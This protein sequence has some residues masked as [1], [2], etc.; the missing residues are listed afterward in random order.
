MKKR[1]FLIIALFFFSLTG[2]CRP[3]AY[4]LKDYE[5]AL[6]GGRNLNSLSTTQFILIGAKNIPVERNLFLRVEPTLEYI[7][8]K[9]NMFVA[10]ASAV[11]RFTSPRKGITP[12]VDMGAGLNYASRKFYEDR[13]LGSRFLLDLVLGGGFNLGDDYSISFRYRHL[14][15]GGIESS[16]DGFD[17]MYVLLGI[18]FN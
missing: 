18:Y 17:S 4:E 11:L 9:D 14:S 15:N 6:G 1:S 13:D 8:D 16:N 2:I 3:W 10:G 12:F 5:I 7:T